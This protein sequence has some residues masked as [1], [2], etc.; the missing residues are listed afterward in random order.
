M[1]AKARTTHQE[2]HDLG[3]QPPGRP[4]AATGSDGAAPSPALMLQQA[5]DAEI[6]GAADLGE[7]RRWPA[8]ATVG[9]VVVTCGA[10]WAAV[11]IGVARAL[12]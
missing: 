8:L 1:A 4:R 2:A 12:G 9:F 10:F 7:V 5:L 3:R 11:A 6:G